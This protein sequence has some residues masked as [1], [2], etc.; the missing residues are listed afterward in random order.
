[1]EEKEDKVRATRGGG[2]SIPDNQLQSDSKTRQSDSLT[3]CT[4][5]IFT[6]VLATWCSQDIHIPSQVC[7]DFLRRFASLRL[8]T[9]D[10]ANV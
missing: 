5:P 10:R 7:G 6:A 3:V 4:C 1:M 8:A 9:Q 2:N